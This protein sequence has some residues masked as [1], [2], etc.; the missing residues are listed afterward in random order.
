[1]PSVVDPAQ[2]RVAARFTDGTPLLLDKQMGEGHLLA[3][4]IGT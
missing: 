1:M 4:R 3:A 2:A